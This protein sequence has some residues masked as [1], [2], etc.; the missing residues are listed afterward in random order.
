MIADDSHCAVLRAQRAILGRTGL[1]YLC[2]VVALLGNA[3]P[4]GAVTQLYGWQSVTTL[5]PF[6]P[7]DG[8]GLLVYHNKLWLIGGWNSQTAVFPNTTSNEVWNSADGRHWTL[9]KPNTFGTTSFNPRTDWEGRHM[10]GWAVFQD[11]LW[12]LGGDSNQCHYQPNV[13][14][15]S[16]G[17]HWSEVASNV[18][19][20]N[21]VL[22]YTVVFNG[23]LWVM[24]GQS[25]ELDGC[26]GPA[27]SAQVYNDVWT[28]S[29]GANWT[30]VKPASGFGSSWTTV[31]TPKW[32]PRGVI[33]GAV[34]FNGQMW[35]IGGG[36]YGSP[37]TPEVLYNDV[38]SSADGLTWH[39]VLDHAPWDPRIYHDVIVYDGRMWVIGGHRGAGEGN[40]ADAWSSADGVHW[41]QVPGTPWEGRHAASVAVFKGLLWLAAGSTDED[42]ENDVWALSLGGPIVPLIGSQLLQ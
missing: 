18:P 20:G 24:G 22:F 39:R 9:I 40:I 23:K 6:A 5:A 32:S 37:S 3:V 2:A 27:M 35:L 15:S 31:P 30:Q 29:D 36:I 11:K 10:A 26:P 17:V 33:C 19:W 4:L 25:L 8:A 13:W 38:W 14:N 34:V 41:T 1:R 7:R 16:D 42:A 28:S 12:I 21:R